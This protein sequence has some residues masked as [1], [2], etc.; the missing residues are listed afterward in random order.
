MH[1][2]GESQDRSDVKK[3]TRKLAER[4][5]KTQKNWP[6]YM[7]L[8]LYCAFSPGVYLCFASVL[9]KPTVSLCSFPHVA[10]LCF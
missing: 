1:T 4:K 2:R 9:T 7:T 8:T 3:E 10:V 5:T 6:T